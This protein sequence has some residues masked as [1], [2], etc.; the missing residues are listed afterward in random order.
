VLFQAKRGDELVLLDDSSEWYHVRNAAGAEGYMKKDLA[1]PI[2][3]PSPPSAPTAPPAAAASPA[4][5]SGPSIDHQ[6]VGCLAAET[7]PR[8]NARFDPMDVAK[9]RVYFRAGG[10]VNWYYVEMSPEAGGYEGVLPKPKESTRKIDYYIEAFSHALVSARTQEYGPVVAKNKT[11]CDGKMMAAVAASVGKV[12]VGSTTAGA[13]SIP[14]GFEPSAIVVAGAAAAANASAAVASGGSHTLLFVAGGVVVAGGV[15][16][17]AKGGG[18]S[19]APPAAADVTGTWTGPLSSQ[20]TVTGPGVSLVCTVSQNMTLQFAQVGAAISGSG[21]GTVAVGTCNL[22][23][24]G[25]VTGFGGGGAQAFTGTAS[26][27]QIN[28]ATADGG[29]LTG[30]YT[31]TTMSLHYSWTQTSAGEVL[32]DTGTMAL[33]KH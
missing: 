5:S 20:A 2:A 10:T 11:E 30:T 4:G 26:N 6:A 29:T 9:P 23:F 7:F 17:A 28:F 3:A 24:T 33:T 8:L 14:V 22:P 31:A 16:L 19:S 21:T 1:E 32:S 25:T 15:A 18:S 27:G 13:P 12:A